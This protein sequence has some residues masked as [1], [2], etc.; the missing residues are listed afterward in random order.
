MANM[1]LT[2]MWG[3]TITQSYGQCACIRVYSM[4]KADE[5]FLVERDLP[6]AAIMERDKHTDT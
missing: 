2:G 4:H 6:G 3:E 1:Q 5:I